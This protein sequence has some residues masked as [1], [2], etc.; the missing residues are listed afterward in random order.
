MSNENLLAS[1]GWRTGP[2]YTVPEAARLAHVSS[3]TVRRWLYGYE[4]PTSHM[5]P[6][7]EEPKEQPRDSN[8]EVSFLQL[9]EIYV[10]GQFRKRSISL[11]RVRRAHEYARRAWEPNY[12]FARLK[13]ASDGPRILAEFEAAEPGG[14]FVVLNPESGQ[15]TLPGHVVTAIETFDFDERELV[16]RWFPVARTVPIVIDPKF[17]AGLPTIPDRRV[18]V[19]AIHKRWKDGGQLIDFIASD[20][21]LQ[22]AIVEQVLRYADRVAA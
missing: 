19:G 5:A 15:L 4:T 6:V 12:P 21:Q 8:I 20:L 22:P 17:S 16:S 13:F 10:A 18:T 3:S 1:N 14:K 11:Q 9:A 7:F 2:L